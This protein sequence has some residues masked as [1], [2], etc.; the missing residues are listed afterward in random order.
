MPPPF[1][2]FH[3][4]LQ[5]YAEAVLALLRCPFCPV[6]VRSGKQKPVSRLHLLLLL[7]LL[8][9]FHSVHMPNLTTTQKNLVLSSRTRVMNHPKKVTLTVSDLRNTKQTFNHPLPSLHS[10]IG[11]HL[12]Y[13]YSPVLSFFSSSTQSYLSRNPPHPP[14]TVVALFSFLVLSSIV[15]ICAVVFG[16]HLQCLL[17]H[18]PTITTTPTKS[19][20]K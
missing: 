19:E 14:L 1:Y 20:S 11:H 5:P 3:F 8:S 4:H 13:P 16:S 18:N 7:L 6:L 9:T 15:V 17:Y 12:N 2:S 10:K